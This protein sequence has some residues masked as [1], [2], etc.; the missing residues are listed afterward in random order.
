MAMN[1][2]PAESCGF[3]VGR[4]VRSQSKRPPLQDP[5]TLNGDHPGLAPN[6]RKAAK[7]HCMDLSLIP[8][9]LAMTAGCLPEKRIVWSPDGQR[10]GRHAER[11]CSLLTP[12]ESFCPSRV[13]SN[14]GAV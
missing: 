11:G 10:G 6:G 4:K 14:A 1:A 3:L 8:E 9:R 12:R 7:S 13:N 2:K 5:D